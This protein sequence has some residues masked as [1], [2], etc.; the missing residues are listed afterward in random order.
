MKFRILNT[1]SAA[2]C[3]VSA[4]ALTAPSPALANAWDDTVIVRAHDLDLSTDAGAQRLLRRLDSA[5]ERVCGGAILQQFAAAR[6]AYRRCY[7]STM[8]ETLAAL[9]A[10]RVHAHYAERLARRAETRRG[11]LS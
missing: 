5:V 1:A 8:A 2:L 10:P 11:R 3:V 9:D 6:R 7:E 4:L